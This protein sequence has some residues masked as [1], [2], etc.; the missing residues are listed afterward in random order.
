MSTM[1]KTFLEHAQDYREYGFSIIPQAQD[2]KPLI[3]WTQYQE[4]KP[5][6]EEIE[7]WWTTWPDANVGLVCGKISGI[8]VI[9]LDTEK[10]IEEARDFGLRS[11]ECPKVKTP[12]QGRHYHFAYVDGLASGQYGENKIEVKNDGHLITLPPSTR[13]GRIYEW[14]SPLKISLPKIP[15]AFLDHL[16]LIG[17]SRNP[18]SQER[19]EKP[20]SGSTLL[21]VESKP[22]CFKEGERN[23][24][25]FSTANKM[26]RGGVSGDDIRESIYH[27][28]DV[29]CDPP[30]LQPEVDGIIKSAIERVV[31]KERNLSEEVRAFVLEAD[32]SFRISDVCTALNVTEKGDRAAVQKALSRLKKDR[33]IESTDK[34]YGG[35]RKIDADMEKLDILKASIEPLP[36]VWPFGLEKL[37]DIQSK[38]IVVLAGSKNV[39]KS[40]FLLNLAGLNMKT[41]EVHYF[42]NE[43][44]ESEVKVRLSKF[45]G[46]DLEEWDKWVHFWNRSRNFADVIKP[47][48]INIIDY[49]ENLEGEDYKI[50]GYIGK[51]WE[52]LD[53]GIAVVGLQKKRDRDIGYGGEATQDRSRLYLAM[54]AGKIKI[55]NAKN[56]HDPK[57]N[58]NGRERSFK[59]VNGCK[60]IEVDE[61]RDP[62]DVE[63][64]KILIGQRSRGSHS[65]ALT[66]PLQRNPGG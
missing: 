9:D 45:E 54:D 50:K 6:P 10:A 8:T 28:N 44:G 29:H 34:G 17:N 49:L 23:E 61:W 1:D 59:L 48:A 32:G 13:E 38:N 37:V 51:V 52:K 31:G 47:N 19:R 18:R 42:S 21:Q 2:K 60:F 58:P 40:A 3:S 14:E 65:K 22:R 33:L 41:H 16:R 26:A 56:W 20:E 36:I 64:A 39:G 12:R 11:Y 24:A 43:M 5:T 4:R 35:Y 27:L 57:A 62:E 25:L 30:L 7:A 63:Q 55:V 66:K 53:R 46:I 15:Q